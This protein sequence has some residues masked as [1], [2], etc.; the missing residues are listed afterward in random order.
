MIEINENYS[1]FLTLDKN[2]KHY[3]SF[4]MLELHKFSNEYKNKSTLT[5][6]YIYAKKSTFP[7]KQDIYKNLSRSQEDLEQ[8][9]ITEDMLKEIHS[10]EM[11]KKIEQIELDK[12]LI[13]LNISEDDYHFNNFYEILLKNIT[14]TMNY[15][16]PI[17]IEEFDEYVEFLENP[18]YDN[19][20]FTSI[21]DFASYSE[22]QR[23]YSEMFKFINQFSYDDIYRKIE[24]DLEKELN[25]I[26]NKDN[27]STNIKSTY[28]DIE[29][30]F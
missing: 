22:E 20:D 8:S 4:K 9:G 25:I 23:G 1:F 19:E 3:F 7:I 5:K 17:T 12:K 27:K 6:D 11:H 10:N 13:D 14:E 2:K 15:H 16:H 29:A 21:S 18:E 30:P 26:E 28:K 24:K